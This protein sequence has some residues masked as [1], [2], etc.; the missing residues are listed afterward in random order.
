MGVKDL[1]VSDLIDLNA[2]MWQANIINELFNERDVQNIASLT[3]INE[4]EED[5]HQW[6]FT[7]HGE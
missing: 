5:K 1:T 4:V 6:K 2:H 7:P 3:I